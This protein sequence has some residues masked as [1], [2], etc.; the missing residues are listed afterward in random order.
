MNNLGKCYLQ[1]ARQQIE[2]ERAYFYWLPLI[3]DGETRAQGLLRAASPGPMLKALKQAAGAEAQGLLNEAVAYLRQAIDAD[4]SYIPARLNLASA[5]LYLGRTHPA[6]AV[7]AEARELAPDDPDLQGLEAL[8]LY[9]TSDAGLDLWSSAVAKL[10]T[11]AA[12]PDAPAALVFNLARLLAVRG[13]AAEARSH[14]DRLTGM[15]ALL[16]APIQTIVCREQRG[17]LEAA[18]LRFSPKSVQASPWKWPLPI[19]ALETAS[20]AAMQNTLLGWQVIEFDWFKDKLHGNIY[21][22]PGGLAEVLEIDDL[23]QMQVL[24][25]EHLGRVRD[26]SAHCAQR[27]KV[28]LLSEGIVW[29]CED[30]AALTSGDEVKELWW[31]A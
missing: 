18:C 31:V 16:P 15:S 19:T 1:L 30:W 26:L 5:Y 2:P 7:L 8:A 21:R 13:R 20:A 14:W 10:E 22:H 3:L 9:E 27:L 17:E 4:P 29:S 24:H 23:V 25:G 11:L 12:A 6:S 28:H